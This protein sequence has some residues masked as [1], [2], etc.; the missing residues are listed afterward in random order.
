MASIEPFYFSS[1]GRKIYLSKK[2]GEICRNEDHIKMYGTPF[3]KF[4]NYKEN[5]AWLFFFTFLLIGGS[6]ILY[7]WIAPS[8]WW[9]NLFFILV[10]LGVLF[11]WVFGVIL[12]FLVNTKDIRKELKENRTK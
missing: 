7:Y 11:M 8:H 3:D 9:R 4:K 12:D 6:V 1:S 2:G 10:C 5:V